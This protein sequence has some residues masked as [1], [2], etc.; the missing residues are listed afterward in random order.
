MDKNKDNI[1]ELN[2]LNIGD[3]AK[4]A[5]TMGADSLLIVWLG[6]NWTAMTGTQTQMPTFL[7]AWS[8][9]VASLSA[10]LSPT[11]TPTI[12]PSPIPTITPTP[13]VI[14]PTPT[15]GRHTY[16]LTGTVF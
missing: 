8:Q 16:T 14:Q 9:Y 11:P 10:S 6:Q 12:L 13:S 15:P 2:P 3:I 4:T 7:D 1:V 5:Q